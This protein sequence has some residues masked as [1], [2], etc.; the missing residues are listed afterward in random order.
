ME[1]N[2]ETKPVEINAEGFDEEKNVLEELLGTPED[3]DLASEL[4]SGE[5]KTGIQCNS[6]I[7]T[8]SVTTPPPTSSSSRKSNEETTESR[9]KSVESKNSK[10]EHHKSGHNDKE[11]PRSDHSHKSEEDKRS[12]DT[13]NN[14]KVSNSNVHES[15]KKDSSQEKESTRKSDKNIPDEKKSKN[16][17]SPKCDTEASKNV[18]DS[19]KKSESERSA[20]E[21]ADEESCSCAEHS[22]VQSSS[23]SH[24]TKSSRASKSPTRKS[25]NHD[26]RQCFLEYKRD[27]SRDRPAKGTKRHRPKRQKSPTSSKRVTNPR[28]YNSLLKYFFRDAVY[29][30]MKSNNHENVVLSKA[31][32]VWS[33]P[34]QNE[35][36]LNR[37]F[38]EFRNVIL[39]FSIKESGRFQGFARLASESR[40]NAQPVQWVL[41]PGLSLKALGGIFSLDWICR[42]EL[43][44]SK[45]LHLFNPLNENK[46]VK[47]AR[48]GQEIEP[49][50]GEELCRL[51]PPDETSD[52]ITFLKRMKKQTLAKPKT[53]HSRSSDHRTNW[54]EQPRRLSRS[55]PPVDN[56]NNHSNSNKRKRSGR[57]PSEQPFPPARRVKR[58][59][60][61][62]RSDNLRERRLSTRDNFRND[63]SNDYSRPPVYSSKNY[64][65]YDRNV[66]DFPRRAPRP[67][68]RERRYNNFKYP[69]RRY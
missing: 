18:T 44:F 37:A 41:P 51:F 58:D 6:D 66:N 11:S 31:K 22:S 12:K 48:D 34:P 24:S 61:D 64:Q 40:H 62:Q 2:V 38:K 47:I 39:I 10:D 63:N 13:K 30:V 69:D 4:N 42:K 17:Q 57:S 7:T 45:T 67:V 21:S 16:G 3:D 68:T 43:T 65:Q 26:V 32:G 56:Y 25:P 52:L 28:D 53:S 19:D 8:V 9:N 20:E 49:S 15:S 29:F 36:K 33:T 59:Y 60:R 55:H 27:R 46:P 1:T 54:S 50:V 35:H 14:S 23:P 5:R